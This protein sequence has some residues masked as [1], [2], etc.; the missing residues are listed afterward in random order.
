MRLFIN[1]TAFGKIPV[2]VNGS[3]D[4]ATRLEKKRFSRQGWHGRLGLPHSDT[5]P[6]S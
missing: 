1:F 3:A 5:T 2:E 4:V 6:R